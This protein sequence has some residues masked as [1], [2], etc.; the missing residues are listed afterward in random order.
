M[1]PLPPISL[2]NTT[3][4]PDAPQMLVA[5]QAE[6]LPNNFLAKGLVLVNW[7]I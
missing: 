7:G 4:S 6:I 3:Y 2:Y 5:Y 1:R